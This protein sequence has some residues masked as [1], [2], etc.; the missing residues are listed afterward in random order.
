MS[1]QLT[2]ILLFCFPV[3]TPLTERQAV[4]RDEFAHAMSKIRIGATRDQVLDAL[5]P[6]DAIRR[7]EAVLTYPGRP[8]VVEARDWEPH[9][10][11]ADASEI[12]HYG[13]DVATG[14]PTL[15][16]V[17]FGADGTSHRAWRH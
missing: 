6:P 15:G 14:F 4:S 8:D 2:T 13:T 10:T 5:G 7:G 1:L 12:W 17:Y 3:M 9:L 16:R 11:R